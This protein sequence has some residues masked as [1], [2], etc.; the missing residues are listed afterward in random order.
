MEDIIH[1]EVKRVDEA[2][3]AALVVGVILKIIVAAIAIVRAAKAAA[4]PS[5]F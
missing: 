5:K 4:S 2:R 3:T 1:V